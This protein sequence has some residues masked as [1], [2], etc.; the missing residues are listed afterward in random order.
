MKKT[1]IL[2]ITLFCISCNKNIS[3][4]IATKMMQLKSE[5]ELPKDYSCLDKY[6]EDKEIIFLGEASHGEGKTFEVKTQIV[7]YLLEKKGFNTIALEGMDFLQMEYINGRNVLKDNLADNFENE[8]Y[9]YWNPW[10]PAKQLIPFE[11]LIKTKK[12][13]WSV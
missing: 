13:H 2:I 12:F 5:N 3:A 7:K 4:E 8:W 6:I 10:S 9:D 1:T 11:G